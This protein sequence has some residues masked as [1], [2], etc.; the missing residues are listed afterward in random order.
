MYMDWLYIV[1]GHAPILLLFLS[2]YFLWNL[3]TIRFYYLYGFF[4]NTILNLLLKGIF[5][6]PRP[7]EDVTKFETGLRH[8]KAF[9]FKDE[10]I[11]FNIFG[12]PS[13]HLQSCLYSTIFVFLSL[14]RYD[15][16]FLYV[17]LSLLSMYQRVHYKYHT[18]VQTV[19]GSFVGSLM[20]MGVYYFVK[21]KVKGKI[22]EKPDDYGPV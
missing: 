5:R 8:G 13:G 19:V 18:I 12:M 9:L 21:Q 20:A 15:I 4:I 1:G 3:Q 16:L 22:R 6:Q 7:S 17:M 10:G 11:P 14:K 2:I